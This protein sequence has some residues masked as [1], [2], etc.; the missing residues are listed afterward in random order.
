MCEAECLCAENISLKDIAQS[1]RGK[2]IMHYIP[3]YLAP[4]KP[5]IHIVASLGLALSSREFANQN[6][7]KT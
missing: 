3:S 2:L 1:R 5:L 6:F 4:A 7:F